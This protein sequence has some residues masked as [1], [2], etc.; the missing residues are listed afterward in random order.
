MI[1]VKI[2]SPSRTEVASQAH[3]QSESYPCTQRCSP[4]FLLLS[5]NSRMEG[6]DEE[7]PTMTGNAKL[8]Y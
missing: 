1:K 5:E 8:A 7:A 6:P 4:D 2:P 3:L